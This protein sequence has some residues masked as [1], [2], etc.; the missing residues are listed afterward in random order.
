MRKYPNIFFAGQITGVEGYT[1]SVGTGLMAGINASRLI[2]DL[3]LVVPPEETM[4]GSLVRYITSKTGTLQPMT[5]VM[6]LLPPLNQKVKSKEEKKRLL[7]E[8]AIR[9]MKAFKEEILKE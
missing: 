3:D 2:R 4:L 9:A 8:R 5:P 7:A 1:A 6:G